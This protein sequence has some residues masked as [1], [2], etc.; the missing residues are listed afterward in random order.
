MWDTRKRECQKGE[1]ETGKRIK[2]VK[3][4]VAKWEKF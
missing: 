2:V 3:N 1:R 4:L